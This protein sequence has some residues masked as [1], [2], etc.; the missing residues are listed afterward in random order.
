MMVWYMVVVRGWLVSGTGR[1][2]RDD[3]PVIVVPVVLRVGVDDAREQRE[4]NGCVA[5]LAS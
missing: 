1:L 3:R 5:E 4:H 2:G